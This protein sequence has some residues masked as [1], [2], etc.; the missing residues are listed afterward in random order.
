METGTWARSRAKTRR[1]RIV[2]IKKL[3]TN[4]AHVDVGKYKPLHWYATNGDSQQQVTSI[5]NTCS[6]FGHGKLV[7][8]VYHLEEKGYKNTETGSTQRIVDHE[9]QGSSEIRCSVKSKVKQAKLKRIT[10]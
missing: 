4:T 9:R 3:D 6:T 2:L 1:S 5:E 10:K 8:L 7:C